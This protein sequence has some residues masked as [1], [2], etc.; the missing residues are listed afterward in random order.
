[1]A[2]NLPVFVTGGSKMSYRKTRWSKTGG[3][4]LC[5][6][7]VSTLFITHCHQPLTLRLS[8]PLEEADSFSQND[9]P[10][11]NSTLTIIAINVGQGDATLLITPSWKTILIDG[12]FVEKGTNSILPLFAR[13]GI[14]QL[15]YLFISHYDADHI[16]GIPEVI[17]GLDGK[18]GTEDDLLPEASYD[19]GETPDSA[20][21]FFTNYLNAV[22]STRQMLQPGEEIVLE[23]GVSIQCPIVNGETSAGENIN[24]ASDDENGH[25]M[26]L[27]ITYGSFKYFT[28]GDLTG[29]GYSGSNLTENLEDLVAPLIGEVDILHINHHGSET[30][31]SRTFLQTL[32]PTVSLI[33]TGNNNPH[34]HPDPTVLNR[35]HEIGTSV[36]QTEAGSG[37][38]L[39][40]AL[41]L[42]E[43]IFIFV[44]EDGS[45]EVNGDVYR[46]K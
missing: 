35:L 18:S 24:L 26:G 39:P 7:I 33:S 27:L 5:C 20:N 11:T 23:D 46:S 13:L 30:S 38:L 1:M 36:Y 29:G 4:F 12:G 34:G 2:Y 16:G 40:E 32:S 28:A 6:L 31:S 9:T 3:F 21:E 45:Y 25:S 44:N 14:R 37:G 15:D 42:N 43:S 17:N 8:E 10:L 19:R 22:G 41:I